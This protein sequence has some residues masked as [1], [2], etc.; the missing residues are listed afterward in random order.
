MAPNWGGKRKG[1]GRKKGISVVYKTFSVSLPE[2]ADWECCLSN[3][4]TDR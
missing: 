1:A 3:L 2:D 4:E